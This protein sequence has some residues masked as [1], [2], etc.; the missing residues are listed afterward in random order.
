[1]LLSRGHNGKRIFLNAA[2]ENFEQRN[3][4]SI[5]IFNNK[6]LLEVFKRLP[7]GKETSVCACVSKRWLTLLC[8]VHKDEIAESNGYLARSL[9][10]AIVVRT[11]N[12][13]DLTKLSIRGNN[14]RHSVTY[15]GLK[16]ISRGSPTLKE[17]SLWNVSYV[18]DEGLS[19]SARE[20]HLSEKLDLF[21]CPRN[22]GILECFMF[23]H[24]ACVII[25][26]FISVLNFWGSK[27]C[28]K[29]VP[30]CVV[31]MLCLFLL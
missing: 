22:R 3:H 4:P 31:K 17:H 20:C 28:T 30:D 18:G 13:G 27:F 2:F 5:E 7:S 9:L 11:S 19:Q 25:L 23:S 15:I 12:R 6:F 29:L 16:D 10:V 21:Q 14:L 8:T 26:I 1:M 24:K